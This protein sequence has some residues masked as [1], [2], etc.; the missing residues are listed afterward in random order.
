MKIAFSTLGCPDWSW[1]EIYPMA[2][3]LGFDGIEIRGL[4]N[5]IYAYR[6]PP[7]APQAIARTMSELS[8]I[9]VEVSCFS[10]ACCVKDAEHIR[11]TMAE[12]LATIDLAAQAGVPY[13]R[14]L[15]DRHPQVEGPVDDQVVAAALRTL[16]EHA[17]ASG[18][19]V[20]IETNGVY[21]DSARMKSLLRRVSHPAIRVLWDIH[22]PIRFFGEQP[23]HTYAVLADEIAYVHIKDSL[24]LPD[25]SIRYRLLGEGDLGV[26]A[27]LEV[28]HHAGYQGYVSLEWVK[29]WSGDLED[30]AI[31]FPHFA[32]Y[33]KRFLNDRGR[34]ETSVEP[35][36]AATGKTVPA[37]TAGPIPST[38]G[39]RIWEKDILV[40]ITM[41]GLIQTVADLFPDQ[42]AVAYVT[43]DYR[44][45]YAELRDEIDRVARGFLAM[46]ARKGDH[47]AIWSTNHP[48]WLLTFFA[49]AR[50]GCVL[51]TVN[52]SYKIHEL[53]YLLRQSDTQ[54][55]VMMDA[56][57]DADYVAILN[58]V[59][60]ELAQSAPGRLQAARLPRLRTVVNFCSDQPGCYT[61]QDV[62][63][64]AGEIP[65]SRL[66]EIEAT[67]GAH[68]V[69]NM[70]Y[71]SGTTG[72]PKGVMLTHYNII[73]NGKCI[74]DCMD[75]STAD[76]LLIPVPFFHCFGMVLAILAAVTHG[77][78]MVPLE[79][80][81]PANVL[82][83]IREE[84]CTAMHGVPTMFIATL[85]HPDFAL[86][87]FSTM[88]T[89]IMAGSP[90]PVKVM[91]DVVD[92]MHMHEITIVFG[93]T[94]SSPGCTQ[95][96]VD[97]PIELRVATVGRALPGV[98]CRIVDP[99]TNEPVADGIAGEF[100]ARGYNIMKGYYNM[101]EATAA[102][103]DAD[104]WLHT[105]DLAVRDA[106]G[107]YKI[108]GRIKDMII[109]GGENIY[110]KEI[111]E[112]LYTH[113]AVTDVQ[114]VGVPDPTYGEAVLAAVI[115]K[116]GATCGE[117]ELQAYV[118]GHMARH[119]TPRYILFVDEFPM[120]ASGKIQKYKIREWAIEHLHLE[121]AAAIETA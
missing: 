76:K 109:R 74:G 32:H 7:F 120:T 63:R 87:N 16:A 92:R 116:E 82:K 107:Y 95:S 39:F 105:G 9:G 29:R 113:P 93:Q 121:E 118:Q 12:G 23:A 10:S 52:T 78:T 84:R 61:W 102:A 57:K 114:V 69:V 77:T 106:Q 101:P 119:K 36:P 20:L 15:A 54:F 42:P 99:A 37:V 34:R 18:V 58:E 3:D 88:R 40:D 35:P 80:F 117:A 1:N 75:F 26:E 70:Q 85:E 94:E 86:T 103:I 53:E 115:R 13:V 43:Q 98:E 71:T 11:S 65:P 67:L 31:V 81:Q 28:L 60:P 83:A 33:M 47:I 22:H 90:C 59:C 8:E 89:G 108:T 19:T 104:G 21:A 50:I 38:A 49:A 73:N 46:G 72:F 6:T 41:N 112:F 5:E 97:D 110:P 66:D 4:G 30:A 45:T 68:D 2:K 17:A 44:R 51:V 25:G 14:V 27:A 111:E 91:Q 62:L 64:R 48:Q 24:R 96:R 56:Y 100:V 79:Y 55:L